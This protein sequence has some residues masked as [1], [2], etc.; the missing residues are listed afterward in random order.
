MINRDGHAGYINPQGLA[1]PYG[2]ATLFTGALPA[3]LWANPTATTP[4]PVN[5][6][7]GAGAGH[8]LLLRTAGL[9][10]LHGEFAGQSL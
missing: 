7:A 10:R 9:L 4:N 3:C 2:D 1:I 6:C 5:N 8:D